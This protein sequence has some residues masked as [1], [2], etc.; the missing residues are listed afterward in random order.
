MRILLTLIY[1]SHILASCHLK[2]ENFQADNISVQT[3][4]FVDTT[5][6]AVIKSG[7]R[8]HFKV[9]INTESLS[10]LGKNPGGFLEL[11]DYIIQRIEKSDKQLGSNFQLGISLNLK[12]DISEINK[13]IKDLSSKKKKIDAVTNNVDYVTANFQSKPSNGL[14]AKY[15]G[16]LGIDVR[17]YQ[18]VQELA[19]DDSFHFDRCK[20][21]IKQGNNQASKPAINIIISQ[22]TFSKKLRRHMIQCLALANHRSYAINLVMTPKL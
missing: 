14:F 20:K 11:Q 7:V 17:D 19:I 12:K 22:E 18:P 9:T 16:K 8:D 5:I 21:A 3:I 4:Q 2:S 6:D 1:G 15:L 10:D 13:I